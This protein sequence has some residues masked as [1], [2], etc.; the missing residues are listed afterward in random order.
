MS[1]CEALLGSTASA[2]NERVVAEGNDLASKMVADSW[3]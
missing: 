3:S 1:L 2:P